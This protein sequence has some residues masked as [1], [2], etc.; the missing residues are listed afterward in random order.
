MAYKFVLKNMFQKTVEQKPYWKITLLEVDDKDENS[1]NQYNVWSAASYDYMKGVVVTRTVVEF[2]SSVSDKKGTLPDGLKDA[3]VDWKVVSQTFAD[4]VLAVYTLASSI[5]QFWY[6]STKDLVIPDS[7]GTFDK[8]IKFVLDQTINKLIQLEK[9][10]P[11]Y[12]EGVIN[13]NPRVAHLEFEQFKLLCDDMEAGDGVLLKNNTEWEGVFKDNDIGVVDLSKGWDPRDT[14]GDYK[15]LL[16]RLIRTQVL[17]SMSAIHASFTVQLPL[18][19]TNISPGFPVVFSK[20]QDL[21]MG[22]IGAVDNVASADGVGSTNISVSNLVSI[23]DAITLTSVKLEALWTYSGQSLGFDFVNP[24]LTESQVSY[25]RFDWRQAALFNVR[26]FIRDNYNVF[27][28]E[29][30]FKKGLSGMTFSD[31][32]PLLE[33]TTGKQDSSFN[34]PDMTGIDSEIWWDAIG[35]KVSQTVSSSEV[36]G[37]DFISVK[38]AVI[39]WFKTNSLSRISVLRDYLEFPYSFFK[40][41]ILRV[42]MQRILTRRTTAAV[43][44]ILDSFTEELDELAADAMDS[45]TGE[46]SEDKAE[47]Y[48]LRLNAIISQIAGYFGLIPGQLTDIDQWLFRIVPI[49]TGFSE[50]P[51]DVYGALCIPRKIFS[52]DDALFI[53]D[54]L[55]ENEGGMVKPL[56]YEN[57]SLAD[58]DVM[59]V[60]R[61]VHKFIRDIRDTVKAYRGLEELTEG[62][63]T[64]DARGG[65]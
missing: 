48:E 47:E 30:G 54:P 27:K 37:A 39:K 58:N 33:F 1:A 15:S 23:K 24:L 38:N 36:Y 59:T 26:N 9:A 61:N 65:E 29:E 56:K 2:D 17:R 3:A 41:E 52:N 50:A 44:Y 31:D 34:S 42:Y 22:G 40:T 53:D 51:I 21:F 62:E 8:K 49:C 19:Y 10:I 13:G 11:G 18:N 64:L 45:V 46:V 28:D 12:S 7:V 43:N 4:S 60:A 16:L 63:H 32:I 6:V 55:K 20:Q 57:R 35:F 25:L 5:T 14:P